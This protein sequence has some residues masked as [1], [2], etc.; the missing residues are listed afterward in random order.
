MIAGTVVGQNYGEA[1]TDD[2][3]LTLSALVETV[4]T[5]GK[6]IAVVEGEIRDVCQKKGCWMIMG[7]GDVEVRVTFKDYGFFVPVNSTGR[8]ARVQGVLAVQEISEDEARHFA[9]DAGKEK[10]EIEL[11]KGPQKAVS[12]IASGVSI[13]E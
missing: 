5:Q 2:P 6:A 10:N 1:I 7:D 13:K 11:I 3:G 8:M 4:K 9:E 12:M